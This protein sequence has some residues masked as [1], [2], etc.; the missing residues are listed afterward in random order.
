[1][2]TDFE[3]WLLVQS[4]RLMREWI[5]TGP[6]IPAQIAFEKTDKGVAIHIMYDETKPKVRHISINDILDWKPTA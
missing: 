6:C 2:S 3:E 4:D 5:T 1:M